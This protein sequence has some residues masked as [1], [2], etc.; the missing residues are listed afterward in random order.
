MRRLL[1]FV[2]FILLINSVYSQ[3]NDTYQKGVSAEKN[4]NAIL[5]LAPYSV[6]GVGFD[7]RYEGV[8]GSVRLFDKLLPSY[9]KIK[10]TD[11]YLQLE[12]DIDLAENFLLFL[13]PKSGALLSL[14]PDMV[15]EVVI[16]NNGKELLFRT[17]VGKRFEKDLKEKKFFQ[18]LKDGTYSFIKMTVKIF[19]EASYKGAYSPDRR[20]DEYETKYRY[21]IS[22]AD[23]T[24]HQLLLLNRKSLVKLFPDKKELITNIIESKAY[25]N[26]EE[27]V[28]AVLDKL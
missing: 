13:H 18:V 22:G 16:N 7:S 25:N 9:L 6:G 28:I 1:L 20:Y 21:Y 10:G 17:S 8:K 4:L 12:T 27:M 15:S 26:D 19:T 3:A 5:N 14:P 23:S 2:A 11:Y 24:F